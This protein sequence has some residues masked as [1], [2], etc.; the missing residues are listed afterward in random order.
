MKCKYCNTKLN[1]WELINWFDKCCDSCHHRR[2]L[3]YAENLVILRRK[4][5]KQYLV[6]SQNELNR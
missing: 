6:K 5:L 3:Q 4:Q 2:Q 1:V